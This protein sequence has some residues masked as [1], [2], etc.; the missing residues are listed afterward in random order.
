MCSCFTSH[1]SISA[2]PLSLW[3]YILPSSFFSLRISPLSFLFPLLSSP[4]IPSAHC[5]L[6]HWWRTWVF[7]SRKLRVCHTQPPVRSCVV[8][9]VDSPFNSF[10]ILRC[11]LS[12]PLPPLPTCSLRHP[13]S[14]Y[15][16]LGRVSPLCVTWLTS[17]RSLSLGSLPLAPLLSFCTGLLATRVVHREC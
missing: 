3:S 12:C 7:S 17:R 6:Q 5:T 13:C 9:V 8:R 4:F 14:V 16:C 15:F 11:L 1:L 10:N 2:L